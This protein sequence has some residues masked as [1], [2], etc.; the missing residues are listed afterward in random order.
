MAKNMARIK[1]GVVV[2]IEWCSDKVPE[3]EVLKSYDGYSICVGDTY[4][5][6]KFYRDGEMVPSDL[7]VAQKTIETLLDQ[8]IELTA[9]MAQM[10]EDVYKQD[11][12][13]NQM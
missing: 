8:N 2:N 4:S 13:Q 11:V 12:E 10:V 9:A 5:D 6:G 7:E 1:N 3:S